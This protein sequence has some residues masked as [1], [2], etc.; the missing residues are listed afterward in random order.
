MSPQPAR[1]SYFFDWWLID[2]RLYDA[3]FAEYAEHGCHRFVL[4]N[5]HCLRL[6]DEP[7][8]AGKL[9][10]W[11]RTFQARFDGAHSHWGETWDLNTVEPENRALMLKNQKRALEFTAEFEAGVLVIHPGYSP[12]ENDPAHPVENLREL[13]VRS[14]ETLLP[15][16]EKLGVSIALENNISP[17]DT[18]DE[19][20]AAVKYFDSPALGCCYDSGHAHLMSSA[21][22]KRPE[23]IQPIAQRLWR[24]KVELTSGDTLERMAPY[25]LCCHLHDNDGL[26]DQHRLPGDGG[27][28]WRHVIET[29]GSRCPRLVSVQSEVARSS[30]T[31]SCRIFRELWEE[32]GVRNP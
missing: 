27:I 10:K 1:V 20:L 18:P 31:K 15:Y 8:F 13:T 4:P 21:P 25:L 9:G 32:R 12:L 11:L 17:A 24:G 6:L 29:L 28:D 7:D 3:V 2:D 19:L 23:D 16:A 26:S 30:I 22:G 5:T 14:L